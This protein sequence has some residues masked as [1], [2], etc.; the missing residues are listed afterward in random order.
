M[1]MKNKLLEN[2][3]K[4]K[5]VYRLFRIKLSENI[6]PSY[7]E[8]G[9]WWILIIIL[10]P[11]WILL[12]LIYHILKYIGETLNHVKVYD[13]DDVDDVDDELHVPNKSHY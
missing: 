3:V 7:V 4:T 6:P 11:I 9:F 12:F 13:E 5:K 10:S 8:V 1:K 2:K